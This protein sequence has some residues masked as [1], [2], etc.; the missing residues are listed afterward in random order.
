MNCQFSPGDY[1]F[2]EREFQHRRFQRWRSGR[3]AVLRVPFH[4]QSHSALIGTTLNFVYFFL[5]I[6][7]L[8]GGKPEWTSRYYSYC[9]S[10]Y[11]SNCA[12]KQLGNFFS[13][14]P[15]SLYMY[16]IYYSTFL[17]SLV[18]WPRVRVG[19]SN[20]NS[21][22]N[23]TFPEKLRTRRQ[24]QEIFTFFFL[25]RRKVQKCFFTLV[26][27][28][29]SMTLSSKFYPVLFSIWNLFF[30]RL[31][32]CRI[33]KF[34]QQTKISHQI[35]Q[36]SLK[37]VPLFASCHFRVSSCVFCCARSTNTKTTHFPLSM[38]LYTTNFNGD[39]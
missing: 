30:F 2:A 1:A 13:I 5:Q 15:S 35:H 7:L 29:F 28:R 19:A 37:F 24:F 4:P 8:M 25:I 9:V 33:R 34:A 6:S 16:M 21:S 17:I 20:V 32:P 38:F 3:P 11:Y 10:Y 36:L 39:K 27:V 26:Y 31:V 18:C 22:A 23:C 12:R 14:Q